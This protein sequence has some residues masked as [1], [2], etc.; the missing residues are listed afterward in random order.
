MSVA[1]AVEVGRPGQIERHDAGADAAALTKLADAIGSKISPMVA[2]EELDDVPWAGHWRHQSESLLVDVSGVCHLFAAVAK[3]RGAVASDD[4]HDAAV[5]EQTLCDAVLAIC[6]SMRLQCRM[7]IG[8]TPA[9][10]WGAAHYGG[11]FGGE[12]LRHGGIGHAWILPPGHGIAASIGE[13]SLLDM[14]VEALR[15]DEPTTKTLSRLGVTTVG[16]C[17]RLPRSGLASRLGTHLIRRIDHWTGDRHESITIHDLP[18][19]A[20]ATW[21]LE[22]PTDDLDIIGD[23]M[24]RLVKM[25]S[26]GLANDGRGALRFAVRLDL[27]DHPP[28]TYDVGLFAPSR[29]VDHLHDLLMHHLGD[30]GGANLLAKQVVSIRLSVIASATMG[31]EQNVLF[32]VGLTANGLAANQTWRSD[33][34]VARLIDSLA[35]RVGR[36]DVVEVL[37]SPDP[38]P[39]ASC[40]TPPLAGNID[41]QTD[42]GKQSSV[43]RRGSRGRRHRSGRNSD[44]VMDHRASSRRGRFGPQTADALRR[45]LVLL[46][47]PMPL[48]VDGL[49]ERLVP[50]QTPTQIAHDDLLGKVPPR[51][52]IAGVFHRITRGWGPERIDSDWWKGRPLCRQYY[53]VETD[54]G[55]WLWIFCDDHE[56]WFLH[57]RF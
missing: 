43:G 22:Y 40:E 39:E 50:P 23:R 41:S 28:L 26:V 38:V 6:R 33:P 11:V 21:D 44:P 36:D 53:R 9:V 51:I 18:A 47:R 14:P 42:R 5:G 8:D 2:V 34:A 3:N 48:V 25:V 31:C 27:A 20:E 16:Q 57:G 17:L 55:L 45:P 35:C 24:R 7:A 19:E 32:D 52:R 56:R 37:P 54:R 12:N 1:R 10:A 13:G 30:N 46:D 15:I 29:N 49:C 4:H